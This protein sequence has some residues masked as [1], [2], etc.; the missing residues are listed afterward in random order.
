LESSGTS[1][2]WITSSCSSKAGPVMGLQTSLTQ[3][4]QLLHLLH[5]EELLLK[6]SIGISTIFVIEFRTGLSF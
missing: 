1:T 2:E 3:S 6:F 4:L 5:L